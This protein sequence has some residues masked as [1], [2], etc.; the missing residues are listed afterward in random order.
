MRKVLFTGTRKGVDGAVIKE[1]FSKYTKQ[2]EDLIIHGACPGVDLQVDSE[3]TRLGYDIAMFPANWSGRGKPAGPFRNE[4]MI[5]LMKPDLVIAL[6]G[7]ESRGTWNTI[8]LA[9]QHNIP[10]IILKQ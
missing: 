9:G 5:T 1:A 3:A 8:R 2:G 6:P 7:P 10:T 4:L